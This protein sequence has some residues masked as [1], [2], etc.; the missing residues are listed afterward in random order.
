[1]MR[2]QTYSQII[3]QLSPK[4]CVVVV[5]V[6][7]C[8]QELPSLVASHSMLSTR[9][10]SYPFKLTSPPPSMTHAVNIAFCAHTYILCLYICVCVRVQEKMLRMEEVMTLTTQLIHMFVQIRFVLIRAKIL[11]FILR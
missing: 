4:H 9:P 3:E 5:V 8:F 1:M 10:L 2:N 7:L 6:L 11:I